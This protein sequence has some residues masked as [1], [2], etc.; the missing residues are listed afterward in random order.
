MGSEMCIRDRDRRGGESNT[1][2]TRYGGRRGRGE[3]RSSQCNARC[4]RGRNNT[5]NARYNA[6]FNRGRDDTRYAVYIN[7][8]GVLQKAQVS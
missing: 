1:R 6:R 4:N 7:V 3:P 5:R 8:C 2:D